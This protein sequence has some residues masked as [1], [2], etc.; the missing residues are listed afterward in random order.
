[1]YGGEKDGVTYTGEDFDFSGG[2]TLEKVEITGNIK[3]I[4]FNIY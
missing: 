4:P 1:M 2:R 3:I